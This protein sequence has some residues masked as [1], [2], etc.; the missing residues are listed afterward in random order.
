MNGFDRVKTLFA[1]R[2]PGDGSEEKT[3]DPAI[4]G[5]CNRKNAADYGHQWRDE[6]GTRLG[7]LRSSLSV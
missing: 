2:K 7:A 5:K 6:E 4:G 3:I 1:N